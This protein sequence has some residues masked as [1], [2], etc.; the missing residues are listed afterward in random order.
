MMAT[1]VAGG[2][3]RVLTPLTPVEIQSVNR[4]AA[5]SAN[6]YWTTWSMT[7]TGGTLMTV[8]FTGGPALTLAEQQ[9]DPGVAASDGLNVYWVTGQL[10]SGGTG[11]P[12]KMPVGGAMPTNLAAG[13][14]IVQD[15]AVDAT[16]VYWIT[17]DRVMKVT[18]K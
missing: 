7:P 13:F 6:L 10:G 17:D 18:P 8:P 15:L 9:E 3:P 1:P 11:A 4:L 16:S 12:L 2:V 5:D 14:T